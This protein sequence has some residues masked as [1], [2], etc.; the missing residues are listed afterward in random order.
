VDSAHSVA[1]HWNQ[2]LL[3]AIR[4]DFP[5]PTVHARNLF[6]VSAAMWDAWAAYD[7]IAVGYFVDED[8]SADDVESARDEA[9]SYAAYRVL[10]HRY[11][12]AAG[13][14]ET[15]AQLDGLMA[16]LCYPTEIVDTTGDSPA[17]IGN[18]IADAV[19]TYGE[20]DGANEVDGYVAPYAPANPPLAF[21]EP[22][23]DMADPNRWQPL[24]FD[25]AFAQN[26]LPVAAGV[27]S[28]VGPQ[29]GY[30]ASFALE[31]SH[32]GLPLD[33][34]PPPLL[35][36]AAT[37]AEFKASVVEV[38]AASHTL[39][40]ADGVTIDI[41]PGA[42]GDS[43]LGTNDGDGHSLNP[44]TG[45]PYEPNVARR[46]DFGRIIAE[47]WAD[48]P[49]SETPP[50]HWNT[51]ANA[52]TDH[53]DLVRSIGGRGPELDPLE[54]DVKLYFA[55]NGALHD[56]AIAAWGAKAHYDYVR[57]ISM[58]RHLGG[59]GQSSDPDLP[60][61]APD[62]LPLVP[63]LIE[64]ITAGSS[65]PGERHAHLTEHIGE[66][67]IHSWQG[68]PADEETQVGGVDWI[69]AIE[70][71]PYQRETFVTPAFPGYVSGHSTFSRAAAE[72]LTAITGDEYFPGGL[73][74]WVIDAGGLE[75]EAGPAT[76]IR[77]QW[78]TYRDAADEAGTSRI[79]GG[80]H[81]RADDFAGRIMGA[82]CGSSAW[83]KALGYWN[84]TATPVSSA[85]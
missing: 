54:W 57:P 58:I 25:V 62:G 16:R 10:R 50:G 34:G 4:R 78:A 11:A 46:A 22:G 5:A 20:S 66:I 81:V 83:E 40:P 24:A 17:A 76:E 61:Y 67:A 31:Q 60:S 8:H 15:T 42:R 80:I 69:R 3:D 71:L 13:V 12:T 38:I 84:G 45:L 7:P 35:G 68:P 27:Q 77:L 23:T 49:Q 43:T 48:G 1:R 82:A 19:I 72:V 52:V 70:W 44:S 14:T 41:G 59:N 63:G 79:Y 28:Y 73:G 18:R 64:V 32:D 33:P 29:W 65:A 37:D 75:F 85:P 9:I 39:D 74:E 6:H 2:V 21:R 36:D 26:G 55:L 53:P 51:L 30:V 56:S 47:F